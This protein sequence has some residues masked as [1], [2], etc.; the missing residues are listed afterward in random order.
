ME[1][2]TAYTFRPR[3]TVERAE[4][5]DFAVGLLLRPDLTKVIQFRVTEEVKP[6]L[7]VF[8]EAR[9]AN[10]RT[11]TR[12]SG[13]GRA[14]RTA[15]ATLRAALEGWMRSLDEAH[16]DTGWAETHLRHHFGDVP[17]SSLFRLGARVRLERLQDL[18]V[19]VSEEPS[20]QGNPAK[21]RKCRSD[22]VAY[23]AAI[24]AYD[25]ALDA[26][27]TTV[28][29]LKAAGV[30]FDL[31]YCNLADRLNDMEAYTRL[32]PRF[33]RSRGKVVDAELVV[34]PSEP[35]DAPEVEVD[36]DAEAPG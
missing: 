36:A 11:A 9:A 10:T 22:L 26:R 8:T 1:M 23:D 18:F 14:F 24:N 31:E 2:T 3:N 5:G 15:S 32:L 29:A 30:A 28:D 27:K 12:A 6:V 13:A 16:D 34:G 21:L 17:L 19:A 7:T 25:R 33:A 4:C 20:L 35:D